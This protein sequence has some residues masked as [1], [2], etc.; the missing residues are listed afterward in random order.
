MCNDLGFTCKDFH[1]VDACCWNASMESDLV[2]LVLMLVLVSEMRISWTFRFEGA[3]VKLEEY[4]ACAW[5]VARILRAL[6]VVTSTA[7][8]SLPVSGV[9][10]RDFF[11]GNLWSFP[12]CV[13]QWRLRE[14]A[15]SLSEYL[16]VW[17]KVD[18]LHAIRLQ[19]LCWF[20]GSL[21]RALNEISLLSKLANSFFICWKC[22]TAVR[23]VNSF[24]KW[25]TKRKTSFQ[26][27]YC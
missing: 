9:E 27:T 7:G 23:E 14:Q 25:T 1:R 21:P 8:V 4:L 10:M 22:E 11:H 19:R 6:M 3:E 16:K 26:A 24:C 2:G 18:N 12:A 13:V 5:V 15:I 17:G 20:H